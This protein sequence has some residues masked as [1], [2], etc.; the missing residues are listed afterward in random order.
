MRGFRHVVGDSERLEVLIRGTISPPDIEGGRRSLSA[1]TAGGGGIDRAQLKLAEYRGCGGA[2]LGVAQVNVH[3][4]GRLIR[5][6]VA[7]AS[8]GEAVQRACHTASRR[9]DRLRRRLT[10]TPA[11]PPDF[12][13]EAWDRR[14]IRRTGPHRTGPD[15]RIARHKGYALA[16]QEADAAALTLDLRDYDFHLFIEASTGEQ[17]L[18]QRVGPEGYRLRLRRP[19]RLRDREF[20]APVVVDET[21]LP[22]LGLAQA[23]RRLDAERA[24]F[25]GFVSVSTGRGTVLYRRF[26][27]HLGIVTSVW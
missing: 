12:A 14:E 1:S 17:A 23:V 9:L 18:M 21:P 4:A 11:G 24:E 13:G 6:Q 26:D 3:C 16:L 19:S 10:E 2:A 20:A 5:G 15:R 27:G 25:L 7:G 22:Q 8:V